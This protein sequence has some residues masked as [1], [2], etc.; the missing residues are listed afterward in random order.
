MQPSCDHE[1]VS[2]K[3]KF[4]LPLQKAEVETQ[5]EPGSLVAGWCYSANSGLALLI[6]VEGQQG[7]LADTAT[8]VGFLYREAEHKL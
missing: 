6:V 2:T 5:R 7:P 8:P 1:A 3:T 4:C